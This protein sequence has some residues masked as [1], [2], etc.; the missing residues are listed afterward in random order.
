MI[1]KLS[2][3]NF[4]RLALK[5]GLMAFCACFGFLRAE[6]T[7][8]K[9]DSIFYV[10]QQNSASV[11]LW[12]SKS[13]S[14]RSFLNKV[15]SLISFKL[16]YD[17]E[18]D[19]IYIVENKYADYS[20][21][22]AGSEQFVIWSSIE[23]AKY[24]SRKPR[25][26]TFHKLPPQHIRNLFQKWDKTKIEQALQHPRNNYMLDKMEKIVTHIKITDRKYRLVWIRGYSGYF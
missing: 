3:L 5:T 8:E 12:G 19:D 9:L 7:D 17:T 22:S 21:N 10:C 24:D 23:M 20:V 16:D 15:T 11:K 13:R 26:I 25:E 1:M 18:N 14:H 4:K 6:A 2:S